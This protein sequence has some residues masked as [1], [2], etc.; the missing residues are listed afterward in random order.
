MRTI[1]SFL[2]VLLG[3]T[4]SYAQRLNEGMLQDSTRIIYYYCPLNF[5]W[6]LKN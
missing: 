4:A 3:F 6:Q 5:R 2:L 1:L